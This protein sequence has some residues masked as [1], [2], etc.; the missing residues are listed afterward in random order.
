MSQMNDY[1]IQFTASRYH[2]SLKSYRSL[3]ISNRR[4]IE[5]DLGTRICDV[6]SL[7]SQFCENLNDLFLIYYKADLIEILHMDGPKYSQY[8]T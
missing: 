2:F 5:K 4:G 8:L 7:E 6:I 3:N 1:L